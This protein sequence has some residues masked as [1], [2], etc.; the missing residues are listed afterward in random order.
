MF[1]PKDY[2]LIWRL[3]IMILC[4]ISMFIYACECIGLRNIV[5]MM[6]MYLTMLYPINDLNLNLNKQTW[7]ICVPVTIMSYSY[8]ETLNGELLS[9]YKSIWRVINCKECPY[10]LP[11]DVWENNTC[12]WSDLQ[13]GDMYSYLI[14]SPCTLPPFFYVNNVWLDIFII[15]DYW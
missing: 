10:K 5:I 14:E 12:K 8:Q 9:R 7:N 2:S 15:N 13:Y 3:N 6:Y 11:V 1:I 4:V